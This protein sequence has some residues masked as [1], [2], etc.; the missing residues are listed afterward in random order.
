MNIANSSL[1]QAIYRGIRI[2]LGIYVTTLIAS[3]QGQEV[4]GY[5]TFL[6]SLVLIGGQVVSLGVDRLIL[7]K[8]R[9][10]ARRLFAETHSFLVI[11]LVISTI[12]F[13]SKTEYLLIA[14]LIIFDGSNKLSYYY[15][16]SL[17][18]S[19]TAYLAQDGIWI[20]LFITEIFLCDQIFDLVTMFVLAKMTSAVIFL[21]SLRIKLASNIQ[22]FKSSVRQGIV[23]G[24]D[25]LAEIATKNVDVI[26]LTILGFL[27]ELAEY[28]VMMR[29]S[30]FILMPSI[31]FNTK[32]ANKIAKSNP[33][34]LLFLKDISRVSLLISITIFALTI[35][36][37]ENIISY[38]NFSGDVIIY[39][40]LGLGSMIFVATGP[41]HLVLLYQD[42]ARVNAKISLILFCLSLILQSI[43]FFI[44]SPIAFAS[45]Y[46]FI[47][48][49]GAVY[50]AIMVKRILNISVGI[51]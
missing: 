50:R 28:G 5:Y 23:F 11:I 24:L 33:E 7:Q 48:A 12:L 18:K 36:F 3:R 2:F 46:A 32:Y 39:L 20:L 37:F 16:Q 26:L 6:V 25:S 34:R 42:Y 29:L 49:L 15:L 8:N 10:D 38:W 51:F 27:S 22:F 43:A 41:N 19:S 21:V 30:V 1:I 45:F 9:T 14:C 35:L 47:M 4:L 17:K 13:L 40:I 31:I 44:Q